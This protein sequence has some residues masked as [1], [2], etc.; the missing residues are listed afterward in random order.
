M[1]RH[2]IGVSDALNAQ[3]HLDK[4]CLGGR[5]SRPPPEEVDGVCKE[6]QTAAFGE[7]CTLTMDSATKNYAHCP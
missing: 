6:Q 3:N 1:A 4:V 7:L 2:Y 5:S